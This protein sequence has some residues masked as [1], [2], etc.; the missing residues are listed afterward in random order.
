MINRMI[1]NSF[2]T[3]YIYTPLDQLNDSIINCQKSAIR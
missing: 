1:N 3:K 2:N